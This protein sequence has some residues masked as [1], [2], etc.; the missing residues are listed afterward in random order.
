MRQFNYANHLLAFVLMIFYSSYLFSQS[1]IQ[2]TVIDASTGENLEG[3]IVTVV[4][5]EK[6]IGTFTDSYGNYR[7]LASVE[8][9]Y[10]VYFQSPLYEIKTQII[11][12]A[13]KDLDVALGIKADL[14]VGVEAVAY[15]TL[16][17]VTIPSKSK[18]L[19]SMSPVTIHNIGLVELQM[20]PG[21]DLTSCISCKPGMASYQASM[22]L[23]VLNPR[24]FTDGTNLRFVQLID[25]T[26]SNLPCPCFPLANPLGNS[27]LD[28]RLVEIMPGPGSALYGP[29]LFN[30]ALAMFTKSPFDYEGI[31]GY[32]KAGVNTQPIRGGEPF[33]DMGFRIAKKIND[34]FAIKFTGSY[35]KAT[36]FFGF[37]TTHSVTGMNVLDSEEL[38]SRPMNHPSFD[39]VNVYG[40]ELSIPID[41]RNDGNIMM[42][43][44]TGYREDQLYNPEI[45]NIKLNLAAHYKLSKNLELIYDGRYA[46]FDGFQRYYI[47]FYPTLNSTFNNHRLELSGK[48]FNVRTYYTRHN[49]GTAY[50]IMMA[51]T[52]TQRML[53][54]DAEWAADYA[55][56]F[57]GEVPD[58]PAESHMKARMFA[59]QD[60]PGTNSM[61][62]RDAFERAVNNPGPKMIDRSGFYHME[63]SYDLSDD[64][65][66]ASIQVGGSYRNY[67][68]R[69]EGTVYNDQVGPYNGKITFSQYGLYSQATKLLFRDKLLLKGTIRMDGHSYF[70]TRFSPRMATVLSLGDESKHHIRFSVQSAF[71]N[72]SATEGF[73]NRRM[74]GNGRMSTMIGGQWESIKYW[75][76]DLGDGSVLTGPQL[77]NEAVTMMSFRRFSETGNEEMLMS[78]NIQPLRQE[79]LTA[80]EL[81]YKSQALEGRLSADVHGYY[82]NFRDF[83][84]IKS[85]FH[86]PSERSFMFTQNL[87]GKVVG[88]GAVASLDY[89]GKKGYRYGINY[90]YADFNVDEEISN[91]PTIIPGFNTP[92]H[93][94][95]IYLSHANIWKDLGFSTRFRYSSSYVWETAFGIGDIDAYSTIDAAVH[96]HFKPIKSL[97]K[98]G[99]SNIFNNPYN[100]IYGGPSIGGQYYLSITFDDFLF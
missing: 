43:N 96:Y 42:V 34:K 21:V 63:G 83:I 61:E 56:A 25:G 29:N 57:R 22:S 47:M 11:N 49:T 78:A 19:K 9:P 98:L 6:Q 75:S 76:L 15:K 4:K 95:N 44:R 1:I 26:D 30:G 87:P 59:D 32:V 94:L 88:Y 27:E 64:I 46:R 28:V 37:D 52:M 36:D 77:M 7:L 55:R 68:L 54:P 79:Q 23:S 45:N 50:N 35:L 65:K 18:E 40:D 84:G 85:A 24:G 3:V 13:V 91:D 38:L 71:R 41:L 89:M 90:A 53:K 70:E 74:M 10:S 66:F 31:S 8:P 73:H 67:Q 97:V 14:N 33:Y 5:D 99:A 92:N 62:F 82:N 60:V 58:I 20:N 81:G 12:D 2:G 72:P 39:A 80:F 48:K 69:S 51:A 86:M 100:T 17:E 93:I 16:D